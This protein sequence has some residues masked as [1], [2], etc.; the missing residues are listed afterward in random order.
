MVKIFQILP[1]RYFLII[2][3]SLVTIILTISIGKEYYHNHE[4]D[5][6]EH[7]D[8]PVLIITHHLSTGEI[9]EFKLENSFLVQTV[10]EFP[11]YSFLPEPNL[12]LINL[13]GPPNF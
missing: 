8:C 9:S 11:I 5:E 6:K 7:D 1:R 4:A 10:I 12:N 13:R 3:Y 2:A